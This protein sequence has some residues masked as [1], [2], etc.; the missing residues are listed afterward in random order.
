MKL[1]LVLVVFAAGCGGRSFSD[2]S[3][4]FDLTLQ[5][6]E[7]IGTCDGAVKAEPLTVV[8]GNEGQ[9]LPVL[10]DAPSCVRMADDDGEHVHSICTRSCTGCF[11]VYDF[12]LDTTPSSARPLM[13]GR[14]TAEGYVSGCRRLIYSAVGK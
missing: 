7:S 1:V 10:P 2:Q 3:Y 12:T 11:S 9:V 13:T 8:F 6:R 5:P 4:T 14:V